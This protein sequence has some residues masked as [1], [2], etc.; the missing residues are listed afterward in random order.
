[1]SINP[2]LLKSS[3]QLVDL[4]KVKELSS[5][6][7]TE[8]FLNRIEKVNP[9][10][11]SVVQLDRE[12]ALKSA[13][14]ADQQLAKGEE[15]GLLHGLPIT[16]KDLIDIEGFK[17]SY[18]S[19]LYDDYKV[20][21]EATCIKKLRNA[22]AIILG[23]T[24]SP[25]LASAFESDNL[26]YGA[27]NNPYDLSL[28]AGGSSGGEASIIAAAGAPFGLGSDGG[29]SIRVPA[30]YCGVAG[31]KPTQGLLSLAGISLPFSG[32]GALSPFGTL[33]PMSR[34]VEDLILTLPILS[35]P[36]LY[37]CNVSPIPIQDA[38]QVDVSKLKIAYYTHDGGENQVSEDIKKSVEKVAKFFSNSGAEIS[39]EKPRGLERIYDLHWELFFLQGDGGKSV[40][41]SLN[42]CK[43]IS[44]LRQQ[45]HKMASQCSLSVYEMNQRF[46]EIA[47]FRSEV[48]Q[49]LNRY[50]LIICPPCASL[51]K[52]HGRCLSEIRD[53]TYTMAYNLSGSPATVVRCASDSTGLPIGVQLVSNLWKD[54]ISLAAAK[55]VEEEF[56]GWSSEGLALGE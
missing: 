10:L 1:M 37:D 14:K 48:Y 40:R 29:G 23:L 12:G 54:H 33:G 46:R 20:N 3:K 43:E 26:L 31:H 25:E 16:I 15:F 17:C 7:V 53:F 21:Q 38:Q 28:S 24:N 4:I 47:L 18:G 52:P 11:N 56:G 39:E 51:A 44:P 9:K 6:E 50:D 36:D 32:P 5:F 22:G 42:D 19:H 55:V 45:F 2:I 41:A 30:H 27:T 8:A 35:G 49:F 34:Y 13:K